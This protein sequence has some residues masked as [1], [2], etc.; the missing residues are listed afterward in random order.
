MDR[1]N[2][3]SLRQKLVAL[4]PEQLA[5][6]LLKVSVGNEEIQNVVERLLSTDEENLQRF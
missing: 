1:K 2:T 5:D 3:E 6:V 4:G